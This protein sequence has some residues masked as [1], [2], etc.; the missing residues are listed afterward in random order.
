M[1]A[2]YRCDC[3]GQPMSDME[4]GRLKRQLGDL[5][6]EVIHTWHNVSNN[7]HICH[8]C[9]LECFGARPGHLKTLLDVIRQF[10]AELS[11]VVEGSPTQST[12]KGEGG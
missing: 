4:H 3:C 5:K 10:E 9:I 7:G 1:S 2:E 8:N 12:A 6:V 11:S